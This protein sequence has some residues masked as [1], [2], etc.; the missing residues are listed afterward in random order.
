MSLNAL[1]SLDR[2][3]IRVP[4]SRLHLALGLDMDWDKQ[5][6]GNLHG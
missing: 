3:F 4:T 2:K 6:E 1:E 5:R